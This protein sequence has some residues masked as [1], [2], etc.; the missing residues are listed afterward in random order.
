MVQAASNLS[1]IMKEL[2]I[3]W[4]ANLPGG[5]EKNRKIIDKY[6]G[7]IRNW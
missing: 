1:K 6:W 4:S 2:P 5:M 3:F 7:K